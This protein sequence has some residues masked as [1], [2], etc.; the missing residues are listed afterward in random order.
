MPSDGTIMPFNALECLT[1]E[2]LDSWKQI[3][4][5]LKRDIRTVQFWEK[6][7]GL[8]IHR[9]THTARASVFAFAHELD[10]WQTVRHAQPAQLTQPAASPTPAPPPPAANPSSSSVFRPMNALIPAVTIILAGATT[11]LWSAAYKK[12]NRPKHQSLA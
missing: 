2:R 6:R 8:P 12:K 11:L 9:H 10:A 1:S 3:A 7:E 5:H 4:T